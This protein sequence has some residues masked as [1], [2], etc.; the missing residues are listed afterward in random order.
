M[1]IST[2]FP[3][4]HTMNMVAHEGQT[5]TESSFLNKIQS[6]FRKKIL[7]LKKQNFDL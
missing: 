5:K 3:D 6:H 1:D 4:N 2:N 7:I